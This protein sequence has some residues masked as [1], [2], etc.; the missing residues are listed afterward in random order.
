MLASW[1]PQHHMSL[2]FTRRI[3]RKETTM[4][5]ESY[6]QERERAGVSLVYV[7]LPRAIHNGGFE[8]DYLTSLCAKTSS[9]SHVN[10]GLASKPPNSLQKQATRM[11]RDQSKNFQGYQSVRLQFAL[12]TTVSSPFGFLS[13][14]QNQSFRPPHSSSLAA[15]TLEDL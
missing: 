4:Q 12:F 10:S 15:S 6:R 1:R 8:H 3:D 7:D 9:P 11:L 14:M 2:I 13:Q 5:M